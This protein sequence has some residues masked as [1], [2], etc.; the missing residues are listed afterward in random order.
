MQAERPKLY[1]YLLDNNAPET[2]FPIKAAQAG[3][4]LHG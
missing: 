3:I 4:F 1:A 2:I